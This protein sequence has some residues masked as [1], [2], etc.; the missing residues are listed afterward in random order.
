MRLEYKIGGG[1]YTTAE[2]TSKQNNADGLLDVV[3]LKL[4]VLEP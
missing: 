3:T 1:D 4:Q 2:T